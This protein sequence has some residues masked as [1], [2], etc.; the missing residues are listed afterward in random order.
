MAPSSRFRAFAADLQKRRDSATFG[1]QL[2]QGA[3]QFTDEL[4]AVLFPHFGREAHFTAGEIEA[5]FDPRSLEV[6]DLA[7]Q[8]KPR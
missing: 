1:F 8:I 6:V 5:K 7:A 4:L 3:Q 2:K